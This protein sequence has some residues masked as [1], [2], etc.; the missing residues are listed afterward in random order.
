MKTN[1]SWAKR[2]KV[3]SG[4]KVLARRGGQN[5]FN[6]KASRGKQLTQKRWANFTVR[7]KTLTNQLPSL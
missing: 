7:N 5:L 1:K 6:A 3:T 4:G 2:L